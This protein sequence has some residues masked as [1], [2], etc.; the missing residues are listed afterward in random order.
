M[1]RIRHGVVASRE[2]DLTDRRGTPWISLLLGAALLAAVV[3]SVRHF[4]EERAFLRVMQQARPAWL[5]VA[6][7]LQA[8]T[9]LAQGDIW[10]RVGAA[11]DFH[12]S[13]R[14]A[15][16]LGLAKLF[17]DQM[18]PSAGLSS[19][20]LIAR[21]LASRDGAPAA[22]KAA[23]LVNIAS[24][25]LA[26][27][28]ALTAALVIVWRQG[29]AAA[30]VMG[31]A[32]AFLLFSVGLAAAVVELSGHVPPALARAMDRRAAGRGLLSFMTGAD[33][34]LVRNPRLLAET[35]GLQLTIMLLDA[36]TVWTLIGAMGEIVS[37]TRVFASFMIASLVRTMGFIPGGL[38][39]F[40]ATSVLTLR[41]TG[42]SLP[43][44]LA[45]TLL[46]RGLSFWLPMLPGYW[47]SRRAVS[48]G[49]ARP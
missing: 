29:D 21:A 38:G 15:F 48:G 24:Y 47:C 6:A 36:V 31:P 34:S 14:T 1:H 35:I 17:A 39:T 30:M 26:Y 43:V 49:V 13:R 20:M 16:E 42:V 10:R 11:G 19:S 32:A 45:A 22:V 8:A 44:A 25:H 40:E 3:G 2:G 12:L 27:F 9:Y 46:F 28:V 37:P 5:V 23:V 33:P 41:M 4:S 18:L 7:V